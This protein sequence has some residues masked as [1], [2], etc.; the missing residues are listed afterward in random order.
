MLTKAFVALSLLILC[1]CEVPASSGTVE[2]TLQNVSTQDIDS[3]ARLISAVAAVNTG[4]CVE[5][6]CSPNPCT[7]DPQGKSACIGQGDMHMC[8]CPAGQHEDTEGGTGNCVPDTACTPSTCN[9]AGVGT[10]SDEGG[11]L[12]CECVE[13]YTDF[14]CTQCD[15]SFG[16]F[17]DGL[18]GCTASP[19]EICREGQGTGAFRTIIAE[20]EASLGHRPVELELSSAR[21]EVTGTPQGVRSW[22]YLFSGEV[23]LYVQT[24]SG[25]PV[26][27]GTLTIP[28]TEVGL[29]PLEF[30]MSITRATTSSDPQFLDGDF[31]VGISAPTDRQLTEMFGADIKLILDFNAY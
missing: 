9:R 13:G 11:V 8:V 14:N 22:D 10:C 4:A 6:P 19:A 29:A 31:R 2:M 25:F 27:A 12:S 18:G 24:V 20:A 30:D 26:N 23:T 3:Q 17:A 7:G 1:G 5:G 28:P 16:Y 15:A 21:M